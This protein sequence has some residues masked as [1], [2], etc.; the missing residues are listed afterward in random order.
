MSSQ[1]ARPLTSGL[2]ANKVVH[3]SLGS[4]FGQK[5]LYFPTIIE[6][7]LIYFFQYGSFGGGV[8]SDHIQS[9]T[10]FQ[11]TQE[12]GKKNEWSSQSFV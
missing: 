1:T 6:I 9:E 8:R 7:L 3:A 4:R 2:K 5:D 11:T 12:S 10:L